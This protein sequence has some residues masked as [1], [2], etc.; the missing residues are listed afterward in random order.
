MNQFRQMIC[1]FS[2]VVQFSSAELSSVFAS[3]A[4]LGELN[5]N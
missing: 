5:C 2:G 3:T 4:N 1:L